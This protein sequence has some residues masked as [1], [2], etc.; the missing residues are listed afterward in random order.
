MKGF[1]WLWNLH[2]LQR[3][4]SSFLGKLRLTGGRVVTCLPQRCTGLQHPDF[5]SSCPSLIIPCLTP[6]RTRAPPTLPQL[7]LTPTPLASASGISTSGMKP[8]LCGL[9]WALRTMDGRFWTPPLRREAKVTNP[10]SACWCPPSLGLALSHD[11]SIF[12][13]VG[14]GTARS[15]KSS[16]PLGAQRGIKTKVFSK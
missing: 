15:P 13:M 2:S 16:L 11:L 7:H 1:H 14:S 5:L 9:T 12:T 8:G 3:E 4:E 10:L 6:E